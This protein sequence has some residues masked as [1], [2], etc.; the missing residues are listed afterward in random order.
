MVPK[1]R[2]RRAHLSDETPPPIPAGVG[3]LLPDE[4]DTFDRAVEKLALH[5][6]PRDFAVHLVWNLGAWKSMARMVLDAAVVDVDPVKH[7]VRLVPAPDTLHIV[8]RDKPS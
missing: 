2:R 5:G 3:A 6:C 1:K 4:R 8:A 7:H